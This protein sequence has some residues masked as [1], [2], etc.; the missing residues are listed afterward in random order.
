MDEDIY[1]PFTKI[2]TFVKELNNSFGN[3]YQNI[4]LYYKLLKK[5]PVS[6]KGAIKKQN[7]VFSTFLSNN[8]EAI[9]KSDFNLFKDSNISFSD[10]VFINIRQILSESED[11]SVIFKHLQLISILFKKDDK[12]I[13]ALKSENDDREGKFLNK[14]MNKVE[15][16]FNTNDTPETDPMK[17]AM[18]LIQSG[19][20]SD[21]TKEIS[22]GKLNI[23]KLLGNLQGMMK[24]VVKDIKVNKPSNEQEEKKD[25]KDEEI[26]KMMDSMS[27]GDF[28]GAMNLANSMMSQMG[29]QGGMEG[30]LLNMVSSLMG[31]QGGPESIM[32]MLA[33]P[34][35]KVE[36]IKDEDTLE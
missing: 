6:N 2:L 11:A 21:M 20:L 34:P 32:S 27:N 9:L 5:T 22:T 36:S 1:K 14:F 35:A 31:G 26:E 17:A 10:R 29:G 33:P 12:M 13:E 28:S 7:A 18:S 3:K 23:N 24:D 15:T 16:V 19:V 25:E 4:Q 8:E 30:G